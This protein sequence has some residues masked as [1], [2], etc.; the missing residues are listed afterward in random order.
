MDYVTL[1]LVKNLFP[2]SK[3]NYCQIVHNENHWLTL[4]N[5]F[6]NTDEVDVYDY[7]NNAYVAECVIMVVNL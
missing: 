5:I 7:L 3:S 1:F 2:F 4:S 6:C